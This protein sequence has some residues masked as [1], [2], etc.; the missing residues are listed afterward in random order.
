M[1]IKFIDLKPALNLLPGTDLGWVVPEDSLL[2][3]GGP[4][5]LVL[6]SFQYSPAPPGGAENTVLFL[7]VLWVLGN[8][9]EHAC[10]LL[11]MSTSARWTVA[12]LALH[13]DHC[14][15]TQKYQHC[16]HLSH[17]SAVTTLA[18]VC[19]PGYDHPECAPLSPDHSNTIQA[20]PCSNSYPGQK[21]YL[22]A[23]SVCD[24]GKAEHLERPFAPSPHCT[25]WPLAGNLEIG[26]NHR[27][28]NHRSHS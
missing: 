14:A 12:G 22:D 21:K 26:N 24:R 8:D 25:R 5:L 23:E 15:W 2:V 27:L 3:P 17:C 6:S 4:L 19:F 13:E 16:P 28:C 11:V 18:F 7:I 20:L 1:G 10:P 9:S